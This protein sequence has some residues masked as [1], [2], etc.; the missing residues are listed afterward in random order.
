MREKIKDMLELTNIP[1]EKIRKERKRTPWD[2][3]FL[4]EAILWSE[5]SHDAETQCGCVLV[6]DKR[7]IS[8]GYNGFISNIVDDCLPNLRN[9]KY[10]FMIHAEHN[11]ILNCARHGTST[12]GS[13][14][15]ITGPPCN[16]CLQ[17]MW[18]AGIVSIV[19]TN[20]SQPKMIES[21]DSIRIRNVLIQLMNGDYGY[22]RMKFTF[23]PKEKL[24]D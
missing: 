4:R 14:A 17:Y 10:D 11:A 23:I 12:Y 3:I 21:D 9:F 1:N 7:V 2:H 13:I 6:R 24:N 5:R 22:D 18:Q 19:Y 8:T 20:Y 15:Y 16:W